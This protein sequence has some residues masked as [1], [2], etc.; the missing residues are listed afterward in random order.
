M[1]ID[2][3]L[4]TYA[5]R[6]AIGNE[7]TEIR[8]CLQEWGYSSEVFAENFNP[9][10]LGRNFLEYSKI[11][12]EENIIFYHHSI[13]SNIPNFLKDLPGKIIVRYHGITPTEYISDVNQYV[14]YLLTQG[15]EQLNILSSITTLALPNSIYTEDELKT[16][17]FRHTHVFPLLI[18]FDYLDKPAPHILDTYGNDDIINIL[19]VGRVIPQKRQD[20]LLKVFYYFQKINPYS[21]LILVGNTTDFHDYYN[22]LKNMIDDLHIENVIFTNSVTNEELISYYKI[23]DI[24]L[25]MSEWET[26]CVP[27]VESMYFQIP[28]IASNNTAIPGTLKDSGILV[29]KNN[30]DE[31]AELIDIISHNEEMRRKLIKKQNNRLDELSYVKTKEKLMMI[32]KSFL[33][34]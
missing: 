22:F 33:Y 6:D 1:R 17:K 24:F 2:Q 11:A 5:P 32:I 10:C 19:Y 31:I 15:R 9:P 3:F 34:T 21:R 18:N 7:V 14:A 23:A 29:N 8:K 26:F 30:F 4:P 12:S 25:C 16:Y 28:I 27:L 13:G 20:N